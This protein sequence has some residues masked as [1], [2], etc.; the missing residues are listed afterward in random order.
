MRVTGK[1]SRSL[2]LGFF[3]LIQTPLGAGTAPQVS[4]LVLGLLEQTS[5]A[6]FFV[7]LKADPGNTIARSAPAIYDK[8]AR[9]GFV[10]DSLHR[11]TLQSQN[12]L[13]FGSEARERTTKIIGS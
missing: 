2:L 7:V 1:I 5:K 3:V 9:Q 6:D 13:G 12:D 10:V 8:Q 4:P 11:E